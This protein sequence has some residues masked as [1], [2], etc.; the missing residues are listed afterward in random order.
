MVFSSLEPKAKAEDIGGEKSSNPTIHSFIINLFQL[1]HRLFYV[2]LSLQAVIYAWWADNTHRGYRR[3][4]YRRVR[5]GNVPDK[6]YP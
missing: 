1:L 3:Q 4:P 5:A 2:F 6:R